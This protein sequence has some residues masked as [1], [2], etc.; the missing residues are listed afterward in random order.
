MAGPLPP[1]VDDVANQL[2][3]VYLRAQ[4][5][6]DDELAQLVS[7]SKNFRRVSRLR[8]MRLRISLMLDDVDLQATDWLSNEF[9]KVYN[10]G[11]FDGS[12]QAGNQNGWTLV[13]R[14]ALTQL[15]TDT[16]DDLLRATQF[17]RERAK[18]LVRQV[19]KGALEDKLLLGKTAIESGR[20]IATA[21][22]RDGLQ[23]IVYADGS[24]HGL[25]EYGPMVARTKSAVTYN[26][27][28]VNGAQFGG[29]QFW[30]VFDGPDCGWTSH[31]DVE[32]ASGKIV[33]YEESLGWPIAHPNCRRTFGA[34]PD[35]Q[36][37]NQ[38]RDAIPTP[39]TQLEILQ[40]ASADA[41]AAL[42][43]QT[44]ARAQRMT[45]VLDGRDARLAARAAKLAARQ[46][47]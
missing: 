5:T 14:D 2:V 12:F 11:A 31:D 16:F 24:V 19:A 40:A 18:Q 34:R 23:A 20:S 37:A 22:G 8:E 15:V 26:I 21:L 36:T 44:S 42:A 41:R 25:G 3:R 4:A 38:A 27:G 13:P 45:K 10:L 47:V 32:P 9:P 28:S 33:T 35:L 39:E 7:D 17:V 29:V 30:E 43:G 6:I 46:N 1:E